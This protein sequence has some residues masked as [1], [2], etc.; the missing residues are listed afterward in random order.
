MADII[1]EKKLLL[2]SFPTMI[3]LSSSTIMGLI[4]L[5]IVGRIGY[6]EVGAVGI[7]NVVI[8]NLGAIILGIGYEVNIKTAQYF[9]EKNLIGE[10]KSMQNGLVSTLIINLPL[11]MILSFLSE[12]IFSIMGSDTQII[13][14]GKHYLSLRLIALFFTSQIRVF[15]GYLRGLG[16]MKTPMVTAIISNITNIILCL[17]SIYVC[18]CLA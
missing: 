11:L 13:T 4:N 9:G 3:A 1:T 17:T 5:M 12:Y 7:T 2:L 16:D 6:L 14:I 15:V 8:L 18:I 10:T